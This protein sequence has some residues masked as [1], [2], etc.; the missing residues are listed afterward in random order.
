M[1]RDCWLGGEPTP[2]Q[3]GPLGLSRCEDSERLAM[4]TEVGPLAFFGHSPHTEGTYRLVPRRPPEP[5]PCKSGLQNLRVNGPMGG[6]VGRNRGALLSWLIP[7][8]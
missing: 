4:V 3:R 1:L 6:K 7:P 8:D 5:S 2:R